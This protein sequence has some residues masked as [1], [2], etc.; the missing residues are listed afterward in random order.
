MRSQ[1]LTGLATLL[2]AVLVSPTA[3]AGETATLPVRL[4]TRDGD[5]HHLLVEVAA[6]PERRARGLMGRDSLAPDAGMLFL[7]ERS[8]PADAGFWMYRTR[9]P[10]DIAF[11]DA[12]GRIRAVRTMQPCLSNLGFRCPSYL[13]GVS[14]AAALEVNAGYLSARGIQPGD[15]VVFTPRAGS[16]AP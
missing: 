11:L 8:Q 1:R 12:T 16:T 9:I 7:Y 6:T 10:L 2:A 3:S 14:Y 4:E 13:P 5:V 15:R